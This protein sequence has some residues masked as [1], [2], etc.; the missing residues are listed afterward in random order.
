MPALQ[1]DVRRVGLLSGLL[2]DDVLL[3]G[4]RSGDE[5]L[6]V[7][8]VR[9]FQAKVYGVALAVTGDPT[10]AEDVAQQAFERAWRHGATFD[11]RRGS[12]ATWLGAIT[13]NSAIDTV[14]VRRPLPVDADAVIAQVAAGVGPEGA[15]LDHEAASELRAALGRLPAEQARAVVLAGIAGFSASEVAEHEGIPLG[16][17][18]TRIRTALQRLRSALDDQGADR[19]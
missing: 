18:K 15:A 10:V 11:P 12:V 19:G 4:Y 3:A 13:R 8:F 14:R 2:P 5:E 17:A 7:A 6:T 9:R 1:W 16:T